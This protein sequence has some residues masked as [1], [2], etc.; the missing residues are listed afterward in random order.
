MKEVGRGRSSHLDMIS[1]SAPSQDSFGSACRNTSTDFMSANSTKTD[2]CKNMSTKLCFSFH[3]DVK[4]HALNCLFPSMWRILTAFISPYWLKY[5]SNFFCISGVSS[6]NPFCSGAWAYGSIILWSDS[7]CRFFSQTGPLVVV[8]QCDAW[9]F[10]LLCLL[11][12]LA[13]L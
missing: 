9:H 3:L 10:C 8:P 11:P 7:P 6:P 5:S 2:P 1:S 4:K 13:C 12:V